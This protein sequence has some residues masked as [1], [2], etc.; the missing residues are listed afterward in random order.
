[1]AEATP[2]GE[3]WW[4]G[5]EER[6][7]V[8]WYRL[9]GSGLGSGYGGGG[10]ATEGC[11]ESSELPHV[12]QLSLQRRHRRP[13]SPTTAADSNQDA[14]EEIESVKNNNEKKQFLKWRFKVQR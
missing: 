7:R 5:E 14:R 1:M 2:Q 4:A 6:A 11:H 13:P 10:A 3:G 9:L 12:R 8:P